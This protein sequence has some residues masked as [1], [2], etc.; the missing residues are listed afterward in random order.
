MGPEAV[1]RTGRVEAAPCRAVVFL[2]DAGTVLLFSLPT[3]RGLVGSDVVEVT[4]LDDDPV[5]DGA[6]SRTTFPS[7]LFAAAVIVAMLEELDEAASGA[8][9][10]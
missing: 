7:L 5:M 9:A 4:V 8:A 6:I 2:M 10:G 1:V 3:V